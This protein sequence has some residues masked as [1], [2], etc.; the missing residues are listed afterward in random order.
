MLHVMLLKPTESSGHIHRSV[1]PSTICSESLAHCH[2]P[3]NGFFLLPLDEVQF[4]LASH[5]Q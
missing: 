5:Q 2:E 3:R 1:L 4:I